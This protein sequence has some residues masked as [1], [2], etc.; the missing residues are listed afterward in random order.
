[1][2]SPA[3]YSFDPDALLVSMVYFVARLADQP[4]FV[5]AVAAVGGAVWGWGASLPG[6]PR[7]VF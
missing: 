1:V 3:Q 4:A 2:D 6:V 5:Q 7:H